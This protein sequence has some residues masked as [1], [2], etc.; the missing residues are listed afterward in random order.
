MPE[1]EYKN[2][3]LPEG[4]YTCLKVVLGEGMGENWW[5][6]A[7]PPLCF[8]EE[9]FGEMTESSMELLENRLSPESF[10]AIVKDGNINFRF[11]I[12]EEFQKFKVYI[13][14]M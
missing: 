13:K 6:I 3:R 11:R 8:C 14:K 9:V 5:C 10:R 12:V 4:K 7:Y 1:K 2:I